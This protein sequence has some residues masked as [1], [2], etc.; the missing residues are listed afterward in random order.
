MDLFRPRQLS[1]RLTRIQAIPLFSTLDARGLRLVD[2][3][4]HER[5]YA[6]G[7]VIFDQGEEGQAIYLVFEGSVLIRRDG[8]TVAQVGAGGFL[9][10]LALLEGTP[11][12][13]QALAATDCK[14]GVLFRSDFDTLL[15]TNARI[16]SRISLQLAR[17]LGGLIVKARTSEHTL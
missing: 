16:A 5:E 1:D 12:S 4:L 13:A 3:V 8:T 11:R 7:E 9:G 17:Y 10:E 14:L 6:E 2:S 15:E